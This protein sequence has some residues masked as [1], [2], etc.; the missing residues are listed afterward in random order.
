MGACISVCAGVVLIIWSALVLAGVQAVT[1]GAC[2]D[3][4][5][6]GGVVFGAVLL[7][8]AVRRIFGKKN[9]KR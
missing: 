1:I 7:V 3:W 9:R 5:A 8:F 6:W 2:V 4:V